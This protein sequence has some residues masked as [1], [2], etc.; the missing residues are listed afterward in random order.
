MP[1]GRARRRPSRVTLLRPIAPIL[2]S[3]RSAVITASWSSMSTTWP[4]SGR[5]PGPVSRRRRLTTGSRSTLRLRRL[6]S[7]LARSCPG[8]CAARRGRGPRAGVEGAE[9]DHGE[10]LDAEAAQVVLDAGPQLPGLLRDPERR[11]PA[12]VGVGTYLRDDQ[13]VVLGAQRLADHVVNEAGAVELGG[14]HVIDAKLDRAAQQRDGLAAAVVQAFELHRAV[15]DPENGAARERGG[16]VDHEAVSSGGDCNTTGVTRTAATLQLD[17][18][19]IK[20]CQSV[21]DLWPMN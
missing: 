2:P 1:A 10:P 5:S 11:A 3:S 9:V 18:T 12:G 14:V 16:Q 21:T 6:S 4:P 8:C 13:D 19:D 17:L 20:D 15:A 7:T